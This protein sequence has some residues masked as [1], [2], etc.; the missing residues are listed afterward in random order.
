MKVLYVCNSDLGKRGNIGLRTYHVAK[1][2]IEKGH[3]VKIICR[4][5]VKGDIPK[6]HIEYVNF[7][8]RYVNLGLVFTSQFI[9]S[10]FPGRI[11][12]RWIFDEL[13]SRK[14]KQYDADVLHIYDYADK[15]IKVAKEMGMKVVLDTQMAHGK[16]GDKVFGLNREHFNEN[17][18]AKYADKVICSSKFVVD[19]YNDA[20]HKLSKLELIPHGVSLKKIKKVK[21]DK[22]TVI[23]VGLIEPRKGIQYLIEA[24]KSLNLK[25]AE[26]ILL[27]RINKS[28]SKEVSEFKKLHNVT[29]TGFTDP[30]P[31][32]QKADLF[33]FPSMFESSGKVLYEAMAAQLPIIT[34]HNAGPPFDD[35]TC[36]FIVPIMDSNS[37]ADK[38]KILY[39]DKKLRNK[40]GKSARSQVEKLGDW[41]DYGD[42]LL[43][44]Y[45]KLFVK[46]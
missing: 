21:S 28:M 11:I 9:W 32:Y 33:V 41:S 16:T 4:G 6:S 24:W 7:W 31:Y 36:G 29:F 46:N 34:T 3:D 25:N 20:G 37:I 27:G 10:K 39:D 1:Q 35:G 17:E 22:F 14:I 2:A 42:K 30:A 26:L 5:F 44:V 12:Q 15:T 18:S 8:Y 43:G 23:F 38:I 40:M 45:N 13:M 19:S